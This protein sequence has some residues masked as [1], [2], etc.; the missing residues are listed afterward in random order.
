M[1][2]AKT[3]TGYQAASMDGL[4]S[5]VDNIP[6]DCEAFAQTVFDAGRW[7]DVE[8]TPSQTLA[9]VVRRASDPDN[10]PGWF[11]PNTKTIAFVLK[12]QDADEK[13]AKLSAKYR[14]CQTLQGDRLGFAVKVDGKWLDKPNASVRNM[15]VADG[16]SKSD[17][18]KLMGDME[19]SPYSIDDRPFGKEYPGGDRLWNRNHDAYWSVK[20]KQGDLTNTQALISHLGSGLDEVVQTSDGCKSMGINTGAEWLWCW[21]RCSVQRPEVRLPWLTLWS[22]VQGYCGKSTLLDHLKSVLTNNAYL[23]GE[24]GKSGGDWSD[25]LQGKALMLMDESGWPGIS[26]DGLN[27]LISGTELVIAKRHQSKTAAKNYLSL[28]QATNNLSLCPASPGCTRTVVV[29]VP[30]LKTIDPTF[31]TKLAAERAAFAWSLL[32]GPLPARDQAADRLFLP[33]VMT[34]AKLRAISKDRT[35]EQTAEFAAANLRAHAAGG[36]LIGLALDDL[37]QRSA[38]GV[39]KAKFQA[40]L[41]QPCWAEAMEKEGLTFEVSQTKNRDSKSRKSYTITTIKERTHV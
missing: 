2:I 32:N 3:P 19:S 39:S 12:E 38:P 4:R 8:E 10:V 16:Y 40:L 23:L 21:L 11:S 9:K 36:S 20:P 33:P 7:I 29:E 13:A 25:H 5:V 18:D 15:L 24:S 22:Q 37:Y 26:Q 6:A 30:L 35:R 14:L 1:S 27:A 28:M 34:E 41:R 17:A 31:S